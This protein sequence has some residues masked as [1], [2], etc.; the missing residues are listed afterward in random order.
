LTLDY[1]RRNLSPQS[2][3]LANFAVISLSGGQ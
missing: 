3:Y 2:T 1:S